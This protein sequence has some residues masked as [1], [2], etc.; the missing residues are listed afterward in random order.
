MLFELAQDREAEPVV[1]AVFHLDDRRLL[2]VQ[3]STGEA[4]GAKFDLG[5]ALFQVGRVDLVGQAGRGHRT[6]RPR[7]H[8]RRRQDRDATPSDH[9]KPLAH[10]NQSYDYNANDCQ[11]HRRANTRSRSFEMR[12]KLAAL[13]AALFA[14]GVAAQAALSCRW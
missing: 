1:H 10:D 4:A 13:T 7:P 5:D 3:R 8:H 9:L 14:V 6:A 11:L 2:T 12:L